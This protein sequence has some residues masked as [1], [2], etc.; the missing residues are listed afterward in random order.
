MN[1]LKTCLLSI[2]LTVVSYTSQA[3]ILQ[4]YIDNERGS[5]DYD[6][7]QLVVLT[8]DPAVTYYS[9]RIVMDESGQHSVE[10]PGLGSLSNLNLEEYLTLYED[11]ATNPSIGF[12]PSLGYVDHGNPKADM[13]TV[14][15]TG[16]QFY[17]RMLDAN[18]QAITHIDGTKAETEK[19]TF[20]QDLEDYY[21]DD[22]H[23]SPTPWIININPP[24]VPE[25]AT[26]MLALAGVVLLFT[27]R[28]E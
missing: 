25:P 18:G 13:V 28:R 27:R 21:F 16:Y 14:D 9:Y 20:P 19:F 10:L 1:T 6:F 24:M 3:I 15:F 11:G 8:D 5:E 12:E 4:W 26:G 7:A 23:I 22:G 17:F 2:L